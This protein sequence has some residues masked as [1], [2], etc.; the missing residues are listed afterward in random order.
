LCD[1]GRRRSKSDSN[2][3]ADPDFDGHT[4]SDRHTHSHAD[5]HAKRHAYGHAKCH[6]DRHAKCHSNGNPKSHS[7]GNPEF[8]ARMSYSD[9]DADGHGNTKFQ[10]NTD[11]CSH[12]NAH[13]HA[14][15]VV[16]N[17]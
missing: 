2:S 12:R 10:C 5:G 1:S 7:D 11:T 14:A 3:F 15:R 9:R 13:S 4:E 17:V 8:D 16:H 6:C